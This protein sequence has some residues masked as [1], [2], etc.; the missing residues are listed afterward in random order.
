MRRGFSAFTGATIVVM[1]AAACGG[2]PAG[3]L[4]PGATPAPGGV[5]PA[6]VPVGNLCAGIP[7]FSLQTPQPV[8]PDD[9]QLNA[10]FPTQI[11]GQPVTN[12]SSTNYLHSTCYYSGASEDLARFLAIFPPASVPLISTGTADATV[13]GE[14]VQID[15]LRIPGTDPNAIFS[16]FPAFLAAFGVEPAEIPLYQV[17]Q[18]SLGGKN[19][20]VVTDPDGDKSYSVV[21]GDT[22]FTANN[23]TEAQAATIVAAIP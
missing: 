9:P 11:D 21:S 6:P 12:V 7:T 2:A 3:T 13:D 14:E 17:S 22:V 8:I 4:A 10:K 18:T 20:H 23:A 16:N 5:T 15:A 19:V 1:L